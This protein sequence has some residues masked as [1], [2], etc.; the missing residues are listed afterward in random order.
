[1]N[2]LLKETARLLCKKI[3]ESNF[4]T[5]D[6]FSDFESIEDVFITDAIHDLCPLV[7][8]NHRIRYSAIAPIE[9]IANLRIFDVADS[10]VDNEKDCPN[11]SKYKIE[12]IESKSQVYFEAE[13]IINEDRS[14][15]STGAVTLENINNNKDFKVEPPRNLHILSQDLAEAG[16]Y[17]AELAPLVM[18]L[19]EQ[20][21][22]T[23]KALAPLITQMQEQ[24][25]AVA[26]AWA[27]TQTRL[28]NSKTQLLK[29]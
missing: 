3:K 7:I 18:R 20:Q 1:M 5:N 2:Y 22:A 12:K 16:V 21:S 9:F 14:V 25:D 11:T 19:Q 27:P 24:Q 8:T 13:V 23:A 10:I 26:K 6:I 29:H 15:R 28:K 17:V 4:Y